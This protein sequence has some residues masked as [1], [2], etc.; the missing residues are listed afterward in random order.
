MTFLPYIA[1]Q[2]TEECGLIWADNDI[3]VIVKT[4]VGIATIFMLFNI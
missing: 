4:S 2:T 3:R 1:G